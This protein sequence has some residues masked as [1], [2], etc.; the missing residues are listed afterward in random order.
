ML[1]IKNKQKNQEAVPFEKQEADSA[2]HFLGGIWAFWLYELYL[3]VKAVFYKHPQ[4]I[5][6]SVV[7]LTLSGES[8]VLRKRTS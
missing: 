5:I 4:K 8:T 7:H 3:S 1:D 2:K 6:D